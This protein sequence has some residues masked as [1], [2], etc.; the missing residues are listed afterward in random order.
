MLL[1]PFENVFARYLLGGRLMF[2]V[3]YLEVNGTVGMLDFDA[4]GAANAA[5]DFLKGAGVKAIVI[6]NN[7]P[8]E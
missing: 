8:E 3:V 7:D 2:V 6:D 1:L 4:E 5:V